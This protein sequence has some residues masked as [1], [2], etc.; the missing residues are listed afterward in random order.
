MFLPKVITEATIIDAA[1]NHWPLIKEI[2]VQF[3]THVVGNRYG[4]TQ[5]AIC[6]CSVEGIEAR[7]QFTAIS[8]EQLLNKVLHN[9][10][11][12]KDASDIVSDLDT[13]TWTA[14]TPDTNE[15]ES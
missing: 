14:D 7:R 13:L 6:I 11:D 2:H 15:D 9:Q 1:L 10:A 4:A 12:W 3:H 8:P 5:E